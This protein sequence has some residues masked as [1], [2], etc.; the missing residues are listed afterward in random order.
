MSQPEMSTI[1]IVEDE[2]EINNALA[3]F[4]SGLGY[5]VKQCTNGR[6]AVDMIIDNDITPILIIC[7]INM[8]EMTGLEFMKFLLAKNLNLTICMIT[9]DAS[10]ES[11]LEALKLGVSDYI[12]KPLSLKDLAEKIE[13]LVDLGRNK[14]RLQEIQNR[15][16]EM[17]KINQNDN[18]L[19]VMNSNKKTDS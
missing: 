8:P 16:P 19:R 14:L 17:S 9:G 10:S 2:I 4:I 5:T 11:I 15:S 3:E 7:D 12:T 13:T 1:L 6:Q 18:L